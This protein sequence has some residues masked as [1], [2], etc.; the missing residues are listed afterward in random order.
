[1]TF[2]LPGQQHCSGRVI[3][4][5]LKS[6]QN[7]PL[8]GNAQAEATTMQTVE[9][10][11]KQVSQG[12]NKM[13]KKTC[14][15]WTRAHESPTPIHTLLY[16]RK[17]SSVVAPAQIKFKMQNKHEQTTCGESVKYQSIH[18]RMRGK[19]AS[20]HQRRKQGCK[21]LFQHRANRR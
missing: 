6:A 21:G 14:Q 7:H 4:L 18:D 12:E 2:R 20:L 16:I 15:S 3:L 13:Q 1:M 19:H 8:Q 17:S 5:D 9:A 11:C 10:S